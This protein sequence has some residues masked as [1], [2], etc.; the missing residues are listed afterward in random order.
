MEIFVEQVEFALC[1]DKKIRE[2]FEGTER[3]CFKSLGEVP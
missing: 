1:L 3:E 2:D